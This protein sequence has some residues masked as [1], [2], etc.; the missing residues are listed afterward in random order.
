M[1]EQKRLIRREILARR[2]T[3]VGTVVS[4]QRMVKF[5][6]TVAGAQAWVVD[7]DIGQNRVLRD[8]LI[9]AGT[10]GRFFAQLGQTVALRRNALGRFDVVGPADRVMGVAE[11]TL[12]DLNGAVPTSSSLSGFQTVRRPLEFYLGPTALKGNPSVIFAAAGQQ[13]VR[14]GGSWLVD[15]FA[16]GGGESVRVAGTALNNGVR[17]TVSASASILVLASGVVNEGPVSGVGLGVVGSSRWNN[18]AV[19]FPSVVVINV[20]TGLPI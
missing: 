3:L 14:S 17:T 8:V 4:E 18:G 9:K 12:Y 5:D 1:S 15:G 16:S 11:V 2:E 13:V 7:V 20:A 10:R 6:A 19:G